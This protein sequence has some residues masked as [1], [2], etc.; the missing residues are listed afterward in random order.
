MGE[1]FLTPRER[2]GE[3]ALQ[4]TNKD[5]L[6]IC[7]SPGGPMVYGPFMTSDDT[8]EVLSPAAVADAAWTPVHG[9]PARKPFTPTL[10]AP[11]YS[12]GVY[13]YNEYS[14]RVIDEKEYH[15]N[16]PPQRRRYA[17]DPLVRSHQAHGAGYLNHIWL[18]GLQ[19]P[20]RP[21]DE[22]FVGVLN[23]GFCA[24][25]AAVVGDAYE[26]YR[27][28]LSE[29]FLGKVPVPRCLDAALRAQLQV[30][31]ADFLLHCKWFL[32]RDRV[33][34]VTWLA[35]YTSPQYPR[36]LLMMVPFFSILETERFK[37]RL[38]YAH[39]VFL[40]QYKAGLDGIHGKVW[41]PNLPDQADGEIHIDA[42]GNF[43]Y[44][45]CFGLNCRVTSANVADEY[46]P[47]SEGESRPTVLGGFR[48][49]PVP[50]SAFFPQALR[51]MAGICELLFK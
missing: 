22:A 28:R 18:Q 17:F 2:D 13:V 19:P 31:T 16:E 50:L 6:C 24:G 12:P 5:K 30:L 11:Q 51:P 27:L 4:K 49:V 7:T 10:H 20:T 1:R 41:D 40:H 32:L 42:S 25:L 9:G 33:E 38:P 44:R 48:L 26:R 21:D 37:Q 45:G 15:F 35:R 47:D 43:S 34:V 36:P 23:A 46:A 14:L 29:E 8:S 3:R 39:A